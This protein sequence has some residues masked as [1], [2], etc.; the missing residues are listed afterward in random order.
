MK[1]QTLI[2]TILLIGLASATSYDVYSGDSI[3]FD[4]G[5]DYEYY[6]VIGNSTEVD[7]NI[8]Q[9]GTIVT[10]SF[11]KYSPSDSFSLIFFDSEKQIIT[12]YRGGGSSRRTVIKE[13]QVENRTYIVQEI[14]K[15]DPEEP[16]NLTE[17]DPKE[18]KKNFDKRWYGVFLM[19]FVTFC[20][21]MVW[22]YVILKKNKKCK[23]I[24]K[25]IKKFISSF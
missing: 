16:I 12:E 17:D 8:L 18:E 22:L 4:L 5:Q 24:I 23:K 7:F 3:S 10:I 14:P 19:L 2:L 25:K 6:S 9:N 20:C 21:L 11:S 15:E 13:V 1:Y